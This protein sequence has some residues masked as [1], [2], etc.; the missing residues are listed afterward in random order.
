[1]ART[2]E[3]HEMRSQTDDP[4]R[5]GGGG[6]GG[7][8]CEKNLSYSLENLSKG[9][10]GKKRSRGHRSKSNISKKKKRVKRRGPNGFRNS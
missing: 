5:G 8:G 6:G 9:N 7:G 2:Y 10:L 1:M 3:I 4:M